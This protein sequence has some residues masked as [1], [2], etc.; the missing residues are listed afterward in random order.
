MNIIRLT[1]LLLL[2]S[3]L[4][5]CASSGSTTKTEPSLSDRY[6]HAINQSNRNHASSV[7]WVNYPSDEEVA[8]RVSTGPDDQE[9]SETD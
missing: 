7:I 6:V 9:D 2:L 5:G 1:A 8:R 3:A 4:S